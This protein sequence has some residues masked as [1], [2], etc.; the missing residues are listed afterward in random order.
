MKYPLLTL[1]AVLAFAAMAVAQTQ[2]APAAGAQA[3]AKPAAAQP[4]PAKG[5]KTPPQAKTQDEYAAYLA[6]GQLSAGSDLAAAQKAVQDF[7]AKYPNS[8]LTPQLYL[9][10]MFNAMQANNSDLATDMGREVLKIDATN[11][12]AAVYT[13]YILSETTRESDLDAA[14]KFDEANKD[15]NTGLQNVDTNLVMAGNAPQETVDATKADLKA[16]AYDTL[17]LVAFKRNDFTAA[18]KNFRQSIQVRGEPGE[19]WSHLRLAL[20]LDKQ[21]RYGDALAEAQ[22]ASTLANP[23]DPVAKSSQAEVERLKKLTGSGPSAATPAAPA[24]PAPTK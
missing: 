11:P 23:Q 1:A 18:E 17:G 20:S 12:V 19:P 6:A 2:T 9:S 15:A 5:L 24:T 13:G 4:A 10:L 16:R 22:K 21:K 8:E 14:Q 3:P 7:Q